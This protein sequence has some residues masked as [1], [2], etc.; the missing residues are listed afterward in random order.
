[1]RY[2]LEAPTMETE[3]R[4]PLLALQKGLGSKTKSPLLLESALNDVKMGWNKEL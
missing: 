4:I 2:D 1:M 3:G